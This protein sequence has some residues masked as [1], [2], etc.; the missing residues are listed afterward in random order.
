[1][2]TA[3]L[4]AIDQGDN[5]A[6][7]TSQDLAGNS[8]FVD[9]ANLG[10][11]TIDIG[12][13]EFQDSLPA[14]QAQC[15]NQTVPLDVQGMGS[16]SANALDNGSS[17]CGYL[18]FAVAGASTLDF[19][20][21]DIGTN[22]FTVTVTDVIGRTAV[23][24]GSITVQDI[25]APSAICR[26]RTIQLEDQGNGAI[27]APDVDGGSADACGIST[28]TIDKSIVTCEGTA[29]VTLTATDQNGNSASCTATITAQDVIPPTANCQVRLPLH[30]SFKLMGKSGCD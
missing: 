4:P 5:N 7:N 26:D 3:C 29:T 17:G 1:M 25:T 9:A 28:I 21:N 20:C 18:T 6:N 19:S 8:R 11:A 12:A 22:T 14:I 30:M 10:T 24:S 16:L 15:Q 27:Q 23:C 2:R 13:Y